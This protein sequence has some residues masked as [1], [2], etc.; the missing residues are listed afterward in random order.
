MYI[1]ISVCVC[2]CVWCVRVIITVLRER[3]RE[4]CVSYKQNTRV[5]ITGIHVIII[6]VMIVPTILIVLELT[7]LP[8]SGSPWER[9]SDT[10]AQAT[11]QPSVVALLAKALLFL[12]LWEMTCMAC[13]TPHIWWTWCTHTGWIWLAQRVPNASK[14]MGTS[15]TWTISAG[16]LPYNSTLLGLREFWAYALQACQSPL[17]T[18]HLCYDVCIRARGPRTS[19]LTLRALPCFFLAKTQRWPKTSLQLDL[20]RPTT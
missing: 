18:G 2:V 13:L 7:S 5:Y 17:T 14:W 12:D 1:Y 10:N 11:R 8:M 4:I 15:E 19:A 3:E 20:N 16:Q 6:I 9:T